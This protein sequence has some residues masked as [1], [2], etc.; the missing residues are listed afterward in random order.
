[1]EL[2]TFATSAY[3]PGP[4]PGCRRYDARRARAD[5]VELPRL[6]G[7]LV[8]C[9]GHLEVLTL[10]DNADDLHMGVRMHGKVAACGDTC[11]VQH[12]QWA[13]AHPLRVLVVAKRE[14]IELGNGAHLVQNPVMG[15]AQLHKNGLQK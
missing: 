13:K 14:R 9:A 8:A 12:P 6:Q 2:S 5:D 11:F 10:G 4:E 1:M 15:F 3:R 7:R